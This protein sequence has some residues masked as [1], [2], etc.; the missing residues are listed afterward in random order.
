MASNEP[1]KENGRDRDPWKRNQQEGPPNLDEL[2]QGLIKRF[3]RFMGSKASRGSNGPGGTDNDRADGS[4]SLGIIALAIAV[5][6]GLT[7]IYIVDPAEQAVITR[8]GKYVRTEWPGPH[9][10]P[11]GIEEK[12]IVNVKEVNTDQHMGLM[13][14]R[15]ENIVDVEIAVHYFKSNPQFYLFNIYKPDESLDQITDSALRYVIGHSTLDEVLTSG[16]SE[17]AAKIKEQIINN[18]SDYNSGIQV[19]DV[20]MQP[21]RAPKEV[22]DAFDDAIRAQEDQFRSEN[23]ADAYSMRIVPIAQGKAQRLLEEAAAYKQQVTV[24]AKGDVKKFLALLSEYQMAPQVT[25]DR[26]YLGTIEKVLSNTSKMLLDVGG[27]NI[28]ALPLEKL[29]SSNSNFKK[30]NL[31][32]LS[33]TVDNSHSDLN[34]NV[35]TDEATIDTASESVTI[36][37][38][39]RVAVGRS[40]NRQGRPMR[41]WERGNS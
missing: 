18:L 41:S 26:L 17:I 23:Q 28:L 4:F 20:V 22:K 14:T 10:Y 16:R 21:A 8:F 13:L 15:D 3:S 31:P 9:W 12:E 36:E 35:G 34:N 37:E 38:A 27:T 6:Y 39:A 40:V 29:L 32:T 2:L 24:L 25:R 33:G 30:A 1:G 11:R 5:L 19:T 7:G